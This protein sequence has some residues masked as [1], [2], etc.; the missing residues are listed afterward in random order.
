MLAEQDTNPDNNQENSTLAFAGFLIEIQDYFSW[1]MT[2]KLKWEVDQV[3]VTFGHG[4]VLLRFNYL[5]DMFV[6][7]V[8]KY[9]QFQIKNQR[10][11]QAFFGDESFFPDVVYYDGKCII[12]RFILGEKLGKQDN[13]ADYFYLGQA[14]AK[15]HQTSSEGFGHLTHSNVGDE[16]SSLVYY[17]QRLDNGWAMI[18]HKNLVSPDVL[19]RLK[20]ETHLRLEK[21]D[22]QT[23]V[24]C[25]GDVWRENV[26]YNP[27]TCQLKLIDWEGIGSFT[28][29]MDLAFLHRNYVSESQRSLFLDGYSHSVDQSMVAFYSLLRIVVNF[30]RQHYSR[31]TQASENFLTYSADFLS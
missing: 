28:R 20:N 21:I 8:P 25:H 4:N 14:L 17:N 22:T 19:R 6:F 31:F 1:V 10:R 18:E 13:G 7:R 27:D 12:E 24:L 29:E 26:I 16:V 2:E 15:I 5:G 9:G 23:K 11:A 30:N 3:Q